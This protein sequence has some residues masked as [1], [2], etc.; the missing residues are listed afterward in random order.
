ME[1][2]DLRS[3]SLLSLRVIGVQLSSSSATMAMLYP[4][5]CKNNTEVMG[6]LPEDLPMEL[7]SP[8]QKFE[9]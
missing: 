7:R 8:T 9:K 5:L 1:T 6:L 4:P 2:L 3:L